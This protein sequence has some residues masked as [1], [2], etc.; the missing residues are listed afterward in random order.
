MRLGSLIE[1]NAIARTARNHA[2]MGT[3]MTEIE[4]ESD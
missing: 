3:D 2:G 4:D 1:K